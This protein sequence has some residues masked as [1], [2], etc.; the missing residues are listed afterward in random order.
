MSGTGAIW[1]QPAGGRLRRCD[2]RSSLFSV[3]R[4]CSACAAAG[5]GP[6][7][8]E[9]HDC[10]GWLFFLQQPEGWTAKYGRDNVLLANAPRDEQIIV[11]RLPRDP[12]KSATAY[13]EAVARSFQQSL[14]SFQLSNLTAAGDS[15]VFLVSYSG[16]GKKY[17]GPGAV[18]VKP[19][20]AWW[21]ATAVPRPR[22]WRAARP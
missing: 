13:A 21:V 6:A 17:A 20:A 9:P 10:P 15:A 11:I 3:L 5:T 19:G 14:V 18:V 16:T 1:R 2:R 8:L 22:T 4:G 12:A 7:S